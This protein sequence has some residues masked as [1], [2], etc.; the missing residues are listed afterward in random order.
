MKPYADVPQAHVSMGRDA[1]LDAVLVAAMRDRRINYIVETGTHLGTGSTTSLAEALLGANA[2]HPTLHTIEVNWAHYCHAR[3]HLAQFPFVHCHWGL[4]VPLADAIS[5]IEHDEILA[6]HTREPD[7]Y[8][9]NTTDPRR[10]YLNEVNGMIEANATTDLP[11]P[12]PAPPDGLLPRLL[13]N[14]PPDGT[15]VLLDSSGGIGLLEFQLTLAVMRTKNYL[16]LLDDTAHIK[17]YRSKRHIENSDEFSVMARGEG[18][19]W[20]LARHRPAGG[21]PLNP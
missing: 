20:L 16:L 2:E 7:I 19:D 1:A 17:H 11:P 10:F 13:Q 21:S 3:E 18:R 6:D 4:S 5:F 12:L 8:I 15:L 9:D 14:A